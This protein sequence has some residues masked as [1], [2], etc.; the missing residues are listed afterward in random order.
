MKLV[1]AI[2]QDEDVGFLM[3]ELI[4]NDYRVT[5]FASTGGF[6]KSGNTTIFIGVDDDLVDDC[7]E[8]IKENCSSRTS[9]TTMMNVSTPAEVYSSVPI[10]IQIG[11]ATVFVVNVEDFLRI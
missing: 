11:G 3:D 2:V 5:K 6:L 10:E 8:I 4:E 7:L 1:I 9:T